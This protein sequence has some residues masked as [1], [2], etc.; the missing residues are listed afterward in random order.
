M[1]KFFRKRRGARKPLMRKSTKGGKRS[2]KA[3]KAFVRKVQKII[4]KDVETKIVV[5]NS[6]VTAFNQSINSTGDCLRLM[7]Q[8]SIGGNQSQRIGNTIKLQSLKIRGV[9]TFA[10]PQALAVNCRIGVRMMILRPKAYK[11]WVA[12]ANAFGVGSGNASYTKL[13]ENPTLA[14]GFNGSLQDFN[15]PTNSDCFS[16]VV[17]KR[18]YMS[19]SYTGTLGHTPEMFNTTKFVNLEVPYC[20]NKTLLYDDSSSEPNQ[21]PYFMVLG[22]CKLDGSVFD[23]SVTT[24]L[25]FQ[26]NATARYE[27]A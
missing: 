17:D 18:F 24:N 22:F 16:V 25:T 26:Y 10:V 5:Y 13:L 9:L 1:V 4:H 3:S 20:R 21:F 7:P 19:M 6:N 27:D 8:I 14:S 15:N 2:T 11:D 23:S 12:G